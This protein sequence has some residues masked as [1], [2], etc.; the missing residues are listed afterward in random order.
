MLSHLPLSA[1]MLFSRSSLPSIETSAPNLCLIWVTPERRAER[2]SRIVNDKALSFA[3]EHSAGQGANPR[4]QLA[5]S[6]LEYHVSR[7]DER[8]SEL[9]ARKSNPQRSPKTGH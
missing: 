9:T 6:R 4:T 3:C 8:D 2:L 1:C 7:A 5:H